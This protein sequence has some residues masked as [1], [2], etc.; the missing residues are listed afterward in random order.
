MSYLDM[1]RAAALLVRDPKRYR[2]QDLGALFDRFSLTQ[3]EKNTLEWMSSH[4]L[5]SKYAH[6]M[7]DIRKLVGLRGIQFSKRFIPKKMLDEIWTNLFEPQALQVK[8]YHTAFEFT[9][10]LISNKTAQG[11]LAET[12]PPFIFDLLEF[13]RAQSRLRCYE[14]P[15][16]PLPPKGS[17][18]RTPYFEVLQLKRDIPLFISKLQK[19]PLEEKV[20][21]DVRSVELLLIRRSNY[22]NTRCFEISMEVVDFLKS[23]M[24]TP[25]IKPFPKGYQDLVEVGLCA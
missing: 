15:N 8:S 19:S 20:A 17:R 7:S 9:R 23:E 22:P 25:G 4:S 18:I 6:S 24:K 2:A 5:V 12:C 11:K 10:F 3:K 14:L 1:Q 21:P 13:E 16:F